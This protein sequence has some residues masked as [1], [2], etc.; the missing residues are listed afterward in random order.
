MTT[1]ITF[2]DPSDYGG[3][4]ILSKPRASETLTETG[5]SAQS[6]ITAKQ[7]EVCHIAATAAIYVNYGASPTA[8]ADSGDMI[9]AGGQIDI[10]PMNALD[11]VA[12]ITVA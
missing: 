2:R 7:G 10:G 8:A 9:N 12:I 1:H 11:K 6:T 4:S 5:T 3:S